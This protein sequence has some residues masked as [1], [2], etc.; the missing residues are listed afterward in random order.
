MNRSRPF[1][2][3]LA[4]AVALGAGPSQGA[5]A[6]ADP[7][8][9][10]VMNP[11]KVAQA[12]E[13]DA[14]TLGV[15]A[16][17]WGYPLVRLERVLRTYTQVPANKPPTS[18]RAPLNRIGWAT[19][20]STPADKD[21]PTANNDTLYMSAVVRLSEPY[22]LSVPDTADRYYVINVF[23][24]YHDLEHYIGRRATGTGAGRFALVPPG[25]QGTLPEGVKALPVSTD[26]LWLWG[27]LH[28]R[29][30]EDLAPVLALQEGFDL[31]PL[32]QLGKAGYQAPK[33]E[34]PPLPSI[35]GDD[36]GFF[37]HLGYAMQHNRI[38]TVDAAL[39]GQLQRIGLS[40]EHGFD[41]S[42]LTAEQ[43][44][45]LKR[46]LADG[47][48]V[49]G[50]ATMTSTVLRNGWNVAMVNEFGY[51][52]PGRSVMAGAYLGGNLAE[53]AVY[54][55][56]FTDD[57]GKPLDGQHPYRLTFAK[58]PPV[59]AFWSLTL[60]NAGD[61]MLVDNPIGRY[62]V[63]SDTPGLQVAADGSISIPI[64]HAQPMGEDKANWLPAPRGG[65]YLLLRLYQPDAAILDGRY[66]L[67]QVSRVQ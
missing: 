5:E 28:I 57:R 54:P 16:Y 63:G 9:S 60:Y 40:A 37:T 53:E 30:G 32:S 2:S 31:R 52:Y 23:D 10:L 48:L 65:F 29:Q 42:R 61:K 12:Q 24:M 55:I 20:L 22:V 18:Y 33:E 43:L 49:A 36:L 15:M 14:Y 62:K 66:A 34:L 39:V 59:G 8:I 46:A 44:R 50:K 56:R 21:M 6:F 58:A 27:R 35:E 13:I 4:L 47:P 41:R 3:A 26:K 25:W 11:Q 19:A 38:K 67:P 1:L 7:Q 51:D 45:G 64:Q 17:T